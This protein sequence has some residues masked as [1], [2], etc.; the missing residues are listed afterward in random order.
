M[1]YYFI[2]AV[3]T[4]RK[5]W[6]LQEILAVV[7]MAGAKALA[8]IGPVIDAIPLVPTGIK[9][10]FKTRPY[11]ALVDILD[12]I[13]DALVRVTKRINRTTG[14]MTRKIF[15][16]NVDMRQVDEW[17]AAVR[18]K[19][20]TSTKNVI[21]RLLTLNHFIALFWDE[22]LLLAAEMNKEGHDI[23]D[24]LGVS[25]AKKFGLN[26]AQAKGVVALM[27]TATPV[28]PAQVLAMAKAGTAAW[29][30]AEKAARDAAAGAAKIFGL[31]DGGIVS[32]PASVCTAAIV[33]IAAAG[34][35]TIPPA[36]ASLLGWILAGVLGIAGTAVTTGIT[37]MSVNSKI[38]AQGE[39]D[40]MR[41]QATPPV[42]NVTPATPPR[43]TPAPTK[44]Q[45]KSKTT[46]MLL[47]AGAGAALVLGAPIAVPIAV[48]A[49]AIITLKK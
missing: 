35:V 23:A 46:S 5:P 43:Q 20:D 38:L 16:T 19:M 44:S 22:P 40:A 21:R 18:A 7:N 15:L 28:Q 37:T 11:D 4:S 14:K 33:E 3:P 1:S 17:P 24:G 9:T 41:L 48:G 31:G 39:A 25:V 34:G 36:I 13:E 27:H 12:P 30:A 45:P 10:K 6:T 47:L 29:S 42:V 32:V 8:P 49:L 26:T 2:G